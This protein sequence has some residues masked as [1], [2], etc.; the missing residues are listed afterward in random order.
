MKCFEVDLDELEQSLSDMRE[1]TDVGFKKDAMRE[2]L[3]TL[4]RTFQAFKNNP[5]SLRSKKVP[6]K[7][8]K[9]LSGT[10]L[11]IGCG[12]DKTYIVSNTWVT[13]GYS[14]KVRVGDRFIDLEKEERDRGSALRVDVAEDG[15]PKVINIHGLNIVDDDFVYEIWD[16]YFESR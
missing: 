10:A 7:E 1:I 9:K 2:N 12:G 13:R 6:E 16:T 3:L 5:D 15:L 14:V 11:D 4:N 8:W